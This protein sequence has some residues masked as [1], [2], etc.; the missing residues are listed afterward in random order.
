MTNNQTSNTSAMSF[1]DVL[2]DTASH[3]ECD[4]EARNCADAIATACQVLRL[5]LDHADGAAGA[6]EIVHAQK[7]LRDLAVQLRDNGFWRHD[8]TGLRDVVALIWEADRFLNDQA[9]SASGSAP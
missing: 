5:A 9:L 2:H 1:D 7:T 4:A 6:D 8:R 3:G